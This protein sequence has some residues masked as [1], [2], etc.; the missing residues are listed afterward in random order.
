MTRRPIW[1]DITRFWGTL[2]GINFVLGVATGITMEFQFG[3]NWSLLLALCRRHLRR[4]A[5]DRGPDGLLPRGDVRRADVL[6][7]GQAVE[8]VGHLI[9][10]FMMALGT[11]L[12][13]LWILVANGWMQNPVGA[14]FNPDS[15]RM[16]VT[17]FMA[18]LFNPSPRP[19]SSTRSA[20]AMS[21][22][23]SSCW[24]SRPSICCAAN[25]S[26]SPSGR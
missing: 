20:R 24:A 25:M 1:R 3:M 5:G 15:M 13:A 10:T 19:S 17:D 26:A 18:V 9:V 7:L 8:A 4:A 23:R 21:A 12:S 2:F 11:N 22:P 16:E 14:A 6:R